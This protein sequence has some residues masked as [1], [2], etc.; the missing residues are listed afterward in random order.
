MN[1]TTSTLQQLEDWVQQT[2]L[3]V[4][5]VDN[6]ADGLLQKL[7][8]I[9]QRQHQIDLQAEQPL[10]IGLYGHSVAGKH[11]LLTT[12]LGD[13]HERIE[14]LLGGK[15]LD[16]LTHIN[17]GH[18]PDVAVRF[19]CRELPVAEH[20]PL[21]L[22][23]YNACE[24]AQRMIRQY[25]AT[26]SARFAQPEVIAAKLKEL[27]V[28]RLAQ[29]TP[30]ITQHQLSDIAQTY[31]EAVRR[32]YHLDNAL[33]QQM[34]ELLPWLSS[35]DQASLLAPLWG[36]NATQ[37]A[38]WQ[39]LVDMLNHLGCARK[40]LAPANLLVDTFLLP[41][42]GFLFPATP[43]MQEISADVLVCPLVNHEIG[44]QV[45]LAQHD[46]Q[47]LCAEITLTLN[48]PP[49]L[50]QVEVVDIPLEQ[51]DNYGNA[52][53][54]DKLVVCNAASVRREVNAA[55]KMLARWV[56]KTQASHATTPG[57]IWAITPRDA[58][59]S[60]A[61]LDEGVQRVIGLP[62]KRWGTLQAL[63]S[64]NMHR[65][66]EWLTDAL[67]PAQR[68]RRIE[69][70]HTAL[71]TQINDLFAHLIE[72][73]D[74]T[75]ERARSQAEDLV[76]TLQSR[77][78]I[79]GELLASLLPERQVLQQCWLNHQQLRK[80]QPA[81]F[82]LDIDLFADE[83]SH[84]AQISDVSNFANTVHVLWINH[85]RQLA[86]RR[87]IAHLSG[88]DNTQLQALCQ[89]LIVASYRLKLSQQL[90]TALRQGDGSMAQEITCACAVLG[91]FVSWL[92][93]AHIEP[94]LRPA[95]RVNKGSPVFT[96]Q[97]Q[98]SATTRLV[99]LGDQPARGNTLYVYDW[100][101]ALYTRALEN[102]GYRHPQDV[103]DAQKAQLVALL[104]E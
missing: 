27:Q 63:D 53:Q 82:S 10:T 1:S 8:A 97:V 3:S 92:G 18:A 88:I 14:I 21:L 78:A 98:A 6:E 34:A 19:T 81:E 50:A 45:S 2:R 65:L 4:P 101:V 28:K 11:H 84:T 43:D 41:V 25:H 29:P 12:L 7:A 79:H 66:L 75:P 55:G 24:L 23:L 80:Q 49:K 62:G 100:L 54:P 60:G 33:W 46:L 86:T 42:E 89:L 47:Q 72:G 51:L 38:R 77:A 83:E 61:N 31:H 32:Q 52:L 36:D 58:R 64:R 71:N 87:E 90:D 35:A 22:T 94:T 76:R 67:I 57:L 5:L 95:S 93:Y 85:L 59:F 15:V 9:Q 68:T 70:L 20:Y 39:Q 44:T 37:T 56:D 103:S 99:R 17:P 48:Q 13:N 96:P 73:E 102:I 16:Y 40:I 91:D 104:G 74:L 30:G 69:M 26:S